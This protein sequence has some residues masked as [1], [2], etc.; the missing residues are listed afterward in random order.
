MNMLLA[1]LLVMQI[2]SPSL[3]NDFDYYQIIAE[4]NL[5]RPLGWKKPDLSPKYQLVL[6][7]VVED[8][9][10]SVAYFTRTDRRSG[11]ITI[12][13]EGVTFNGGIVGEIKHHEVLMD[14]GTNYE[15]TRI[16]FLDTSVNGRKSTSARRT[17]SATTGKSTGEST[18]QSTD[19]T[20]GQARRSQ[21]RSTS[22]TSGE[23]WETQVSR[24]QSA[25]PEERSR[26]I[27]QFRQQRGN[28]GGG[29]R[30]GRRGSRRQQ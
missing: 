19:G 25:S 30:G 9:S 6:T 14:S 1:V 15:T 23:G 2:Q 8:R 20:T 5:F 24:F 10:K 17:G 13:K 26:M 3:Q 27:E 21:R 11:G 28:R 22:S 16:A 18:Q 7:K 29:N 12:V 4:N